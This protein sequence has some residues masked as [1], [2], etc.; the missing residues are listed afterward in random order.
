MSAER[1]ET[2]N[3]LSRAYVIAACGHEGSLR[4]SGE[5]Y[6]EHP[7]AVFNILYNELGVRDIDTLAASL[8]HDVTEDTDISLESIEQELGSEVAKLVDG[9]SKIRSQNG[10]KTD[11]ETLRKVT[12]ASFSDPRVGIIKLAD[13][14]H[15][16]RTLEHMQPA[17]QIKKARETLNVYVPLAESLGIWEIKT[18][19]EDLAF[20]Y[21]YP[22]KY[23]EVKAMADTDPR[24]SES[25]QQ[26]WT[27]NIQ[28]LLSLNNIEAEVE[29]RKLGL[30]MIWQK[31]KDLEATGDK[32]GIAAISDFVSLRVVLPNIGSCYNCLGKIEAQYKDDIQTNKFDNF[33][34]EPRT[35][36]YQAMHHSLDLTEG[37]MEIAIVSRKLE[38]FNRFG[39]AVYMNSSYVNPEKLQKFSRILVYTPKE[40]IKFFP[41]GATVLDFA[42]SIN[43]TLGAAATYAIATIYSVQKGEIITSQQVLKLSAP[44]P[45]SATIEILRGPNRPYPDLSQTGEV[46]K[47]TQQTIEQQISAEEERKLI[48]QGRDKMR[49]IL[50]FWGF[51]EFEDINAIFPKDKNGKNLEE[52]IIETFAVSSIDVLYRQLAT[53]NE[54]SISV[55]NFFETKREI[56]NRMNINT[57][58]IQG[59]NISDKGVVLS[60]AQEIYEKGG[61]INGLVVQNNTNEISYTIRIVI[62]GMEKQTREALLKTLANDN[63]F[64][65]VLMV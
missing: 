47:D 57:I 2:S 46:L 28:E 26:S 42:Y 13:R 65:H 43:S 24:S 16:M 17:S 6:I 31:L 40:E 19:L 64:S 9:V 22:T 48:A 3:T 30:W 27:E 60:I 61:N 59:D 33:I 56:I 32:R 12:G 10:E 36:G 11:H 4:K 38:N 53:N 15:N 8:V 39:V 35:N 21:L 54:K 5:D 45:D 18:E 55:T 58:L 14:L 50:S 23:K 1:T 41:P 52:M 25:F 20:Y 29:I 7:V 37:C 49:D 51:L 44:L 63:R 34:L 62:N